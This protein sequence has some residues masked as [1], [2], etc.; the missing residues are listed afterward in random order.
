MLE[1]SMDVET[2]RFESLTDDQLLTETKRLV[3]CERSA[4]TALLRSLV[5]I[6][7][8][9]L[10]LRE[11]C[12]SLFTYCTQVLH[13]AEG[14]AYNRIEAAR[15]ARRFPEVLVALGDGSLTLAT[16]RLLA[17]H[18]TVDNHRE[19]IDRARFRSKRDVETLI[20]TL[21]PRAPVATIIRRVPIKPV[22]TVANTPP[23]RIRKEADEAKV[24]CRPES[25][26]ATVGAS[27]C[28]T[29]AEPIAAPPPDSRPSPSLRPLSPVHYRLQVTLS[30]EAHSKLRR[31]QDLL[32]HAV[33]SG[34]FAAVLDRALTLLVADLERRRC[35]A[36]PVPRRSD[37]SGGSGRHMPAAVKRAVW[38]RD[39]RRCA[40]VGRT[41]RCT[42]T[43]WLEFHHVQ[44]HADG[45]KTSV[46]NIQLRC[47][48]HNQY[49]A[50]LWFEA[51]E[52]GESGSDYETTSETLLVP[53][54]VRSAAALVSPGYRV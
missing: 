45:G 32:R 20:A 2:I 24:A 23:A 11:G 7:A 33:P 49:E 19:L 35:A 26:S 16:A 31:A 46:D 47:R 34:D 30:E 41:G 10:Y 36:T 9:R 52:V 51:G 6:D 5:E 25:P 13:L 37:L 4:T 27:A 42:E 8:R 1:R 14:A 40:F 12:A 53:G 44:P 28:N 18:F 38:R 39:E 3:A 29:H 15:A 22:A 43:A 54:Q 21:A 50:K 17:P 48:A